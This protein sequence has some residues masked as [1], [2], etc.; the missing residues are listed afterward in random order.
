M[1]DAKIPSGE[2][3][4]AYSIPA[5]PP[6]K[7]SRPLRAL[8]MLALLGAVGYGG[9]LGWKWARGTLSTVDTQQQTLER[10]TR[11]VAALREQS[12]ALGASVQR[13]GAALAALDGRLKGDEQALATIGEQLDGGRTRLQLAAVEQ[14][15]L[16]A[17]DR[18]VLARDGRAALQ[19]LELADQRL[20]QLAEPGLIKV[21]EALAK[22]RAALTA[23]VLPDHAGIVLSLAEISRRAPTLP[24]RARAQRRFDPPAVREEPPPDTGVIGRLWRAVKSALSSLFAL[25]RADAPP[26]QLMLPEEETL[27]GQ[28]L[29]LK[30]EGARLALLASDTRAFHALI[31]E[32]RDWLARHYDETH[33]DVKA[34]QAELDRLGRIGLAPAL[35]DISGSLTLLRAR[36]GSAR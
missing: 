29:Q 9:L 27:V 35:P 1:T 6:P 32:A 25:R 13:D 28:I 4:P 15:M 14:L 22:E 20:A 36:L 16:L 19:A 2:Q 12:L 33:A 24:L 26:P 23:L 18:L 7:R 31:G 34:A 10:L 3:R 8:F 11:E 17:N 30:V 21:R 5:P